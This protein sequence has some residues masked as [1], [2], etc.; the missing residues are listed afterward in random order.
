[1]PFINCEI[2]LILTWSENCVISSSTG[3]TKLYVSIVI[4]LTQDNAKL[5]EQLKSGFKITI[6]WNKYQSKLSIDY[7][8]EYEYSDYLIDPSFRA[9]NKF[10]VLS[11]ENNA[12]RTRHTEYFLPKVEIKDYNVM[13]MHETFLMSH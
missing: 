9:V 4:L 6:N 10:F 8:D 5:L 13:M 12:H 3:E 7:S 1:M 11:F 2:N